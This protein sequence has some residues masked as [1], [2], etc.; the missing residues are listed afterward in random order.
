M[1]KAIVSLA[2][3]GSAALAF[4][5]DGAR[6]MTTYVKMT[7]GARLH[8]RVSFPRDYKD[9]DRRAV[10]MDRSP[11]GQFGIELLSD[12]F[13]PGGFI[14][15][16]QDMRGTG[17]SMGHFSN[18]KADAN[19]SLVTGNWVVEQPWSNGEIHL[20]GASA[21]GLGAFTTNYNSPSWLQSQYY[22]WTSS[23]GYEV[24]YPNGAQLYNLL[25]RW[26]SGTVREDDFERCWGEFIENEAKTTWWDDLNFQ[27]HYDMVKRG[28]FG[29]WAGWY[30]IFLVGTLDAYNGYNSQSEP[31]ARH[32][33]R[34]LIDPCGHCQDAAPFFTEDVIAG[35][36]ALG[37][38]QVRP[39]T[40]FLT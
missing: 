2:L 13:L 28:D 34:L 37:L 12:L 16:A 15:V 11:Y 23:I 17:L 29:F 10:I 18:W 9:G 6:T 35:R 40:M 4:D 33:S 32:T 20:F 26:L 8:T 14:T 3:I 7:D 19:D 22:I 24:I 27:G 21:D 25:H 38:M 31:E 5:R 39:P 1:F 36:T 30:D